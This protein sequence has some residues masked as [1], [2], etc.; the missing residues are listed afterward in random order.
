MWGMENQSP[1]SCAAMPEQLVSGFNLAVLE[2]VYSHN[3][4]FISVTCYFIIIVSA[5]GFCLK[6]GFYGHE[7]AINLCLIVSL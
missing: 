3:A 5:N 1:I 2:Q 6:G 7:K 4:A